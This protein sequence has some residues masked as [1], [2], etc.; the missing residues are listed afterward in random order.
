VSGADL[1][2]ALYLIADQMRGMASVGGHF[3]GSVHE[4]ERSHRLMGLA[5]E[6]AALADGDAPEEVRSRFL[7]EPW[8]RF[9]PAIG[10]DAAVFD[11]GGRI[12]LVRIEDGSGWAMPGGLAEIGETPAEAVLRELWEEAGLRGRVGRLLGL[13]DGRRWGS[14][15]KV[16]LV[17]LVFLVECEPLAPT[18]GVEVV[19][20]R[21]FPPDRLPQ[22]M[23]PGHDT[24]VPKVVQLARGTEAFFDPA[25]SHD[26]QLPMYQR[27][28]DS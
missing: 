22:P 17:Q 26:A 7:A 20:A 6:L 14:R 4:A 12:L 3:A 19:E 8:L 2:Q 11:A 21:F 13:F 27:P 18:P 5:A 10:V 25:A 15:A 1:R 23:R 16:H 9:S 28:D 24:R